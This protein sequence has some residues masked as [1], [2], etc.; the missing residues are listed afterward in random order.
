ME[1]RAYVIDDE[2]YISG[3]D[4]MTCRDDEEA[5]QRARLLMDGQ[6]IEVWAGNRLVSLISGDQ[7]GDPPLSF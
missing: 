4:R 6:D 2:G 7:D 3:F 5:L 1:Y